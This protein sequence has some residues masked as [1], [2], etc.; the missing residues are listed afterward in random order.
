MSIV[1]TSL[2]TSIFYHVLFTC[3]SLAVDCGLPDR[4]DHDLFGCVLLLTYT[5]L[6]TQVSAWCT[7]L[8]ICIISSL[9]LYRIYICLESLLNFKNSSFKLTRFKKKKA[10]LHWPWTCNLILLD[11][12]FQLSKNGV[13]TFCNSV[14]GCMEIN[15]YC[16]GV[17]PKPRG[18]RA[19]S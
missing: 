19:S 9:S 3:W 10:W 16:E 11:L 8:K 18:E 13:K 4:M 17:L 6:A 12:L 7:A 5:T 15:L 14:M 1:T 2:L